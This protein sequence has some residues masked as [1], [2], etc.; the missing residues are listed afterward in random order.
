[1]NKNFA[2][3]AEPKGGDCVMLGLKIGPNVSVKYLGDFSGGEAGYTDGRYGYN[4]TFSLRGEPG[5]NELRLYSGDK[6]EYYL[7]GS[8][9]ANPLKDERG[10]PF[11]P[12]LPLSE[13]QILRLTH[14]SNTYVHTEL[15]LNGLYT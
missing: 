4:A 2:G 10:L 6:L 12:D 13:G 1:M 11:Y 3:M 14:V 15:R 9:A 8:R 7:H 5:G